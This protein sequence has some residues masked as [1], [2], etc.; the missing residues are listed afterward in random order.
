MHNPYEIFGLEPDCSDAQVRQAYLEKIKEFP[1]EQFPEEFRVLNETYEL[2]KTRD[3]RISF[4]FRDKDPGV[5]SPIE[6]LCQPRILN[7][8]RQPPPLPVMRKYIK[9]CMK[10]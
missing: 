5:K 7:H 9:Q 4:F 2:I 8:L 6:T 3:L 1:P 10:K